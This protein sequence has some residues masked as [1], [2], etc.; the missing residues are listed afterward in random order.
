VH[1]APLLN[2]TLFSCVPVWAMPLLN[3]DDRLTSPTVAIFVAQLHC[4]KPFLHYTK[5]GPV[6]VTQSHKNHEA[7]LLKNRQQRPK[8]PQT[9]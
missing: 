1:G 4:Q 6:S 9:Y 2:D 3:V 8:L 5:E 7:S